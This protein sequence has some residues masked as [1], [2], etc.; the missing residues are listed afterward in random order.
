MNEIRLQLALAKAGLASRRHA[1]E[2]ITAGRVAVNGRVVTQL[3]TRIDPI[4]DKISVDGAPVLREAPAYFLLNKPKGYVTTAKDP[5]GRQ[6][7]FELLPKTAGRLFAV[8]RLDYNTEGALL[9][10]NDGEL[11]FALM[12][13]SRGVP[14]VYHAKFRGTVD[15]EQLAQLRRG[16]DLPPARPL[17]KDGRPLPTPPGADRRERSAPADV[18]VVTSTGRH[19]WLQFILHEGK[20]RQIHRMAEAV[21]SSLLKLMRIE[22]AGL[23]LNDLPVG[24]ARPLQP[25]EVLELRQSVGLRPFV[26]EQGPLKPKARP[27]PRPAAGPPPATRQPAGRASTRA[28]APTRPAAQKGEWGHKPARKDSWPDDS[29]TARRA[30]PR[31]A[32]RSPSWTAEDRPRREEARAPVGH[33]SG[34][35]RQGSQDRPR[36]EEARPPVGHR[37]G[38][39]RQGFEDRPRRE[40][41]RAPVGHRSGQ[42]RQGFEDRPRREEARAPT[43]DQR[44]GR[45]PR[46]PTPDRGR[47]PG[48]GSGG[49][50]HTRG[51]WHAPPR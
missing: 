37:S 36:R 4:R 22:Y 9:L 28:E 24:E 2:M 42:D 31:P 26:A 17:G 15:K 44:P 48:G 27:E 45:P 11:A 33:R 50:P 25:R 3:G 43:W 5:E 6:T 12:H 34:Q 35:D 10:T 7:V 29:G 47:A 32:R 41:A 13:P 21:G 20:N 16:V 46:A 8:G 40:E 1:E 49:R 18:T 19:T 38:Q 51:D 23:T 14:K 30:E 39:D